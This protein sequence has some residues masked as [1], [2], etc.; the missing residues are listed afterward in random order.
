MDDPRAEEAKAQLILDAFY[1]AG[2]F[3]P[4]DLT[5]AIA[6]VDRDPAGSRILALGETIPRERMDL[7]FARARGTYVS[8]V[9]AEAAT[10][11]GPWL[12]TAGPFHSPEH[13][14]G[15]NDGLS[16]CTGCANDVW[17]G[18]RAESDDQ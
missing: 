13:P 3:A 11:E 5:H 7:R 1:G 2:N 6:Q 18:R 14:E 10:D 9:A 17:V 16:T 15:T 8:V 4:D 12:C